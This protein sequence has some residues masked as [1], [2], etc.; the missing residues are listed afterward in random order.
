MKLN[1]INS[2][3]MTALIICLIKLIKKIVHKQYITII[4]I[5]KTDFISTA[6]RKG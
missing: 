4:Y 3:I 5:G 1:T 6:N 2:T